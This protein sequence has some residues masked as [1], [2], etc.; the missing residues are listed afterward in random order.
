[1]FQAFLPADWHYRC[2]G[3]YACFTWF[4]KLT[5]GESWHYPC[6]FTLWL[7]GK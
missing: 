1:M 3:W 6:A 2:S 4:Y 7:C 5:E